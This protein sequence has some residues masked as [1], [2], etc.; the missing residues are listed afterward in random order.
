VK[1]REDKVYGI[2][3]LLLCGDVNK[4]CENLNTT[5]KLNSIYEEITRRLNVK[6]IV[7]FKAGYFVI[8]P[9]AL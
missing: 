4:L 1:T 6:M 5:N 8:F 2:Y 7:A 3:Q 9:L